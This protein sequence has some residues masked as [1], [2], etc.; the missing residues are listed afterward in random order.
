MITVYLKDGDTITPQPIAAND[1]IPDNAVW[2]D[3]FKV[4]DHDREALSRSL[5]VTL[6][7]AE[8]MHEI[9]ASSRTYT[10]DGSIFLTAP[11]IGEAESA[12]PRSEPIS[13][14]LDGRR[15][16]TLRLAESSPVA[17]YTEW[18]LR[19]PREESD[20]IDILLGLIDAVL[21][22]LADLMEILIR[23]IE[24]IS[25][26]TFREE[27]GRRDGRQKRERNK[28]LQ[29]SLRT[30]G[31]NGRLLAKIRSS[32]TGFERVLG[33]LTTHLADLTKPQ[34]AALTHARHDSISLVQQADFQEQQIAFLLDALVGLISIEQ[35]EIVR[36]L[37]I[38]AT[39][40]LPPTLIASLY[41]MNFANMPELNSPI[42]YPLVLLVM[43]MSVVVPLWYFRRKGWM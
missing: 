12:H 33:F 8:D 28:S 31:R 5:G 24:T 9:E 20:P 38:A 7:T 2:V 23:R 13:F 16:I 42:G 10:T 19:K 29:D 1:P 35:T 27:D 41:G 25:A 4:S 43:L 26:E 22:R 11:M 34:N 39:I 15:L 30:V 18:L 37:S 17:S 32:L 36:V 6:P 21:D 3:A 40:F 14:V